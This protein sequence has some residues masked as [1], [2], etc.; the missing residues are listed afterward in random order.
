MSLT[1]KSYARWRLRQAPSPSAFGDGRVMSEALEHG[2][3][4]FAVCGAIITMQDAL[5]P[6]RGYRVGCDVAAVTRN[7]HKQ[8]AAKSP[9]LGGFF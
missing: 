7:L 1:I 8:A 3:R 5:A 2:G 6:H 9:V 4:H